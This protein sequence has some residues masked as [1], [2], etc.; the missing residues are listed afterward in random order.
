MGKV[1]IVGASAD[2]GKFG[3]KAVRAFLSRGHEVI[4]VHPRETEIEGLAVAASIDVLPAGLDRIT[5]YLP[6]ARTLEALPAAVARAPLE[7]FLNPGTYD[8]AVLEAARAAGVTV[9]VGCAIRDIG[10]D[11][12]DYD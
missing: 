6:P 3:N 4:P 10:E 9:R 7:I 8:A 2:R 12:A 1:A 11:P 5:F